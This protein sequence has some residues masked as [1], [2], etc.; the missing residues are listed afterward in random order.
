MQI[1]HGQVA[2]PPPDPVP[3]NCGTDRPAH[4]EANP[5]LFGDSVP[6]QEVTDE[7]RP[8]NLAA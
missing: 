6:H 3:D 8:P 4:R 5:R 2:Q 7:Q 1:P